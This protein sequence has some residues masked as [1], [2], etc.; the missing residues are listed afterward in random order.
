V[1]H[2]HS[3]Q[4]GTLLPLIVRTTFC[5]NLMAMPMP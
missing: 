3:H 2:L 5:L 4:H 1:Q